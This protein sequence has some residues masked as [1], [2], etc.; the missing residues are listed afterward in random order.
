MWGVLVVCVAITIVLVRVCVAILPFPTLVCPFLIVFW[1]LYALAPHI[2]ALQ[3]I[4]FG[5]SEATSFHPLTAVLLSL[6]QALFSPTISVGFCCFRR[7][8]VE[9]LAPWLGRPDR[10]RHRHGRVLLLPRRRSGSVNLGLY[11]FNGVLTA[12]SVFVICGGQLRLAIFGALVATILTPVIADI[13]LQTL[14]APFV[15]TTWL[16]LALG[17]IGD[18]WFAV[19]PAPASRGRFASQLAPSNPEIDHA[20][21]E[22]PD[23][24]CRPLRTTQVAACRRLEAVSSRRE[25]P[26]AL[27]RRRRRSLSG[28][29][30]L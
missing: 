23:G 12:V 2:D 6:G 18:N 13:G 4:A 16:M 5:P 30:P 29:A 11:G 3:P 21:A 10:R 28:P 17:W 27:Q 24:N 7:R 15:L 1:V 25:R 19:K 14:S 22:R 9:Q 26:L 8:A 20:R